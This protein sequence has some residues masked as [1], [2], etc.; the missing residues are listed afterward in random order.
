M[1]IF[2]SCDTEVI[3]ERTGDGAADSPDAP[4]MVVVA[5][6]KGE[7]ADAVVEKPQAAAAT[8]TAFVKYMAANYTRNMH[9]RRARAA[10]QSKRR[11]S[12]LYTEVRLR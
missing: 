8:S 10:N 11:A 6:E 5:F 3:N 7:D 4:H 2:L 9:A 12:L 1:D